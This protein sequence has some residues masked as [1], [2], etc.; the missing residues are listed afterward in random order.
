MFVYLRIYKSTINPLFIVFWSYYWIHFIT[1]ITKIITIPLLIYQVGTTFIES[2]HISYPFK[3]LSSNYDNVHYHMG[4]FL[5]IDTNL[6][7]IET[8]NGK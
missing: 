4:S 5:S 2:S 7:I 6:Q 3:K 8:D 1:P